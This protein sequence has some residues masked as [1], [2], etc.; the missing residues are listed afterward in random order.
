MDKELCCTWD[1]LLFYCY[2]HKH[3][4]ERKRSA[5]VHWVKV[6]QTRDH[7]CRTEWNHIKNA[8]LSPFPSWCWKKCVVDENNSVLSVPHTGNT[9]NMPA[10]MTERDRFKPSFMPCLQPDTLRFHGMLCYDVVFQ[11]KKHKYRECDWMSKPHIHSAKY[12][13]L[14]C[15]CLPVHIHSR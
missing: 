2:F 4:A 7:S 5:K 1:H 6:K 13:N 8:L 3:K 9:T 10:L 11:S 14:C 12:I 15:T